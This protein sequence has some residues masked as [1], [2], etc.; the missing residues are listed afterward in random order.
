M[1]SKQK[2]NCLYPSLPSFRFIFGFDCLCRRF[3]L[4]LAGCRWRITSIFIMMLSNCFPNSLGCMH[5]H[6]RRKL[7]TSIEKYRP[8][9]THEP[10]CSTYSGNEIISNSMWMLLNRWEPLFRNRAI[11]KLNTVCIYTS[12]RAK[13]NNTTFFF[14]RVWLLF[15]FFPS[16]W[17][18]IRKIK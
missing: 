17:Q 5:H 2:S 7:N 8:A 1:F 3:A 15:R 9:H 11:P 10:L 18:R 4:S 12:N 13:Q 6:H 16:V 14:C